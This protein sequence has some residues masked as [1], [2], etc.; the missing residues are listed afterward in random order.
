MIDRREGDGAI[1]Q[2]L[3]EDASAATMMYGRIAG[4]SPR[5]GRFDAARRHV[6]EQ[7][8]RAEPAGKVIVGRGECRLGPA[9]RDGPRRPP[10]YARFPASP[11]FAAMGQPSA[12]AAASASCRLVTRRRAGTGDAILRQEIE[13]PRSSNSVPSFICAAQLLRISSPTG[14]CDAG[15]ARQRKSR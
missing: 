10:I 4:R 1:L 11:V 13:R 15:A 5:R 14:D 9:G 6:L 12:L 7:N 2:Q 8:L 3:D